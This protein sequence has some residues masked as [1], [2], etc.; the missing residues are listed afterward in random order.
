MK[1]TN[2]YNTFIAVAE[3]CKKTVGTVPLKK[4]PPTVANIKYELISQNP[5]RYTSDEV[6][7]DIY[8]QRHPDATSSDYLQV[9]QACFRCSPL[10]K[11]YGWGF[12]FD[13]D[14]RVALYGMDSQEYQ[15]FL[16]NGDI[17]QKAAFSSKS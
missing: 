5:Y 14:G 8:F 6:L 13:I 15:E 1:S 12:H 7:S 3:Q 11:Y 9:N 17:T 4:I 10:A 2:Y 16:D